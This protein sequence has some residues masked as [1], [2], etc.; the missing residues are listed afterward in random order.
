M[1]SLKDKLKNIGESRLQLEGEL[2]V[3]V[4]LE[5]KRP[6]R[7]SLLQLQDAGLMIDKV[8]GNKVVGRI[9]ADARSSLEA[10]PI[11]VS[12]ETSV[13]LKPD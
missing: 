6:D 1:R 11:V 10:I 2:Q 12:I 9:H 4:E 3:F 8:V 13:Q 5:Q 7:E